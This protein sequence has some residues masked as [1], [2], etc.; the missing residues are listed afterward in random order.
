MD[1]AQFTLVEG[2]LQDQSWFV[3]F[4]HPIV[5][6]ASWVGVRPSI[7]DWLLFADV[8]IMGRFLL[9]GFARER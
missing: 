5:H 9:L 8:N 1:H 3:G 7:Y 6:F 2:D 4:P